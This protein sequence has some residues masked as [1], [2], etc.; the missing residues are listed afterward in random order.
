MET[1]PPPLVLDPDL[2]RQI[3]EALAEDV[4]PGDVTSQTLAPP[5]RRGRATLVAKAHGVLAGTALFVRVFER[6][7]GNPKITATLLAGDGSRVAPGDEV[8]VLEGPAVDLL[9]GERTALNFL[10]RLSAVR[11]ATPEFVAAAGGRARILDTRKTRPGWRR[12][13]KYAVRCGGGEN[14]RFGLFDEAMIKDN[15]VDL[16]GAEVGT[17]VRR[18]REAHGA[19]LRITAEA[20]DRAEA[21]SA[22]AGGAD[23]LL[24]DNFAPSELESLVGHLR[25]LPGGARVELEASG[26]IDLSNVG[27]YA[28]TG[29][30]R[31]SV[32]DVTHSA[33]SLDL[34]LRIEVS[35]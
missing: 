13:E 16:A 7:A 1:Q 33:P 2:D 14:H 20:R 30:D 32:G 9:V 8:L 4:G 12:L 34:S 5:G 6:L 18:L 21:E 11:V 26:G 28:R 17:L 35:G 22:L 19:E 10:Q 15:H 29:V 25:T 24:L 31:I 3:D 27:D 23:V